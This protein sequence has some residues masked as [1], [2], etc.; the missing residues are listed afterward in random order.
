[1][2]IVKTYK[3]YKLVISQKDWM[4]LGRRHG[5]IKK[6]QEEQTES[7]IPVVS[8]DFDG[9]L[10]LF[11]FGRGEGGQKTFHYIGPNP[12]AVEQLKQHLDENHKVVIISA[13]SKEED[14]V[15]GTEDGGPQLAESIKI[16][17]FL[18]DQGV[19]PKYPGQVDI[20]Y[21]GSPEDKLQHIQGSGSRIH[22][23]DHFIRDKKDISKKSPHNSE[24]F[25]T[26]KL[27]GMSSKEIQNLLSHLTGSGRS[28][29]EALVLKHP[30]LR[31]KIANGN[32]HFVRVNPLDQKSDLPNIQEL[33]EQQQNRGEDPNVSKSMLH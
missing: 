2:Q 7:S 26:R 31:E 24:V 5:W 18:K 1:V 21:S 27:Q 23:D 19:S 25:M 29:L 4:D 16:E 32:F 9:T 10:A 3:S 20:K 11:S 12:K 33:M 28:K 13:R 14:D 30:E 22:Y 15:S 17:D 8:F 6:A